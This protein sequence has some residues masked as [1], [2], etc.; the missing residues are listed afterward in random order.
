[1]QASS[2]LR[3]PYWWNRLTAITAFNPPNAKEFEIAASIVC[4]AF[5]KA[6][7]TAY[8]SYRYAPGAMSAYRSQAAAQR[9][10]TTF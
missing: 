8:F 2:W 1:V 5:F 3:V 6:K 7:V 9:A 4:I 10:D